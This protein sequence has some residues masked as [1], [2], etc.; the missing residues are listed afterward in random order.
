MP[1]RSACPLTT[2]AC[3]P[4]SNGMAECFVKIMKYHY[5]R[6]LPKPP[7]NSIDRPLCNPTNAFK[8]YSEEHPHRALLPTS[9]SS[10]QAA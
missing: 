6:H 3:S 9:R 8:H 7:P 10:G 1:G 2:P 4:Q 5:I